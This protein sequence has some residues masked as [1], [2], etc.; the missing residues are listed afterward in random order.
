MK[1]NSWY[2]ESVY[3]GGG[4]PTTLTAEQLD[5]LLA[6]V[7]NGFDLTNL[8]EFTVEAGRPDTITAEKLRVI[9]KYN[10]QRI[11]INPQSMKAATLERIGRAHKPE[12]IAERSSLRGSG[13]PMIN[14]DVI[15]G[16][17]GEETE[18]FV[19]TLEQIWRSH[20]RTSPSIRWR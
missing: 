17:P 11:S 19:R 18:D 16:L 7:V 15:A 9:G 1:E 20:R 10:V 13:D 3:I 14:T 8:K 12:D 6:H 4:T 5:E 2:P